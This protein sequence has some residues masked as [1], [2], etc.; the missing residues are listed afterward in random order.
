MIMGFSRCQKQPG[1]HTIIDT[2]VVHDT[3]T[4]IIHDS[5]THIVHDSV[6]RT[7]TLKPGPDD[8][9]DC[10][11]GN[12]PI[13]INTNLS[14]NP[15]FVASRWTY[16][17]LG[18][19]EGTIR[20]YIEFVALDGLPDSAY[21]RSATLYLYGLAA[22]VGISNPQ[23]NSLYP[24][25]PYSAYTDNSCWLKRVTGNWNED[26]I[27]WSNMPPTTDVNRVA[28]PS[29]TSQ[30]DN[31]ATLDVTKLV[32]DIVYSRQNY[33]FCLQM[34]NEQI[35]RDQNFSGSRSADST[36]W[37]KLVVTYSVH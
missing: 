12:L 8:G 10:L 2:V 24:G 35:Y 18:Y 27:T 7:L 6:T 34:Q 26:S 36:R 4:H 29:T 25:S 32:Q 13:H 23:G 22:G 17:A 9:Q 5:T 3:T 31:N 37:P 28:V 1:I 20:G 14:A 19:G 16:N 33:G 30:F 11:V 15:D 21:I